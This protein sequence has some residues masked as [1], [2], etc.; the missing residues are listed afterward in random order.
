MPE[1][2]RQEYQKSLLKKLNERAETRLT[3]Q[4]DKVS[5]EK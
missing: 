4:G 1:E 2:S 3:S 5:A